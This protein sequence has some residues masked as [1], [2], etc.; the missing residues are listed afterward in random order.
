MDQVV[1][2]VDF[3]HPWSDLIG[4]LKFQDTPALARTL[5]RLLAK[6]VLQSAER[7]A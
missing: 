7:Y 2:A 6:S 5:A 1:V 4:E 3:A